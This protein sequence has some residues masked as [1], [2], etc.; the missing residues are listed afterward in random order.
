M[1]IM[2]INRPL[3]QAVLTVLRVLVTGGSGYLGTHVR[4]FFNAEDLSRRSHLDVLSPLDATRVGVYEVVIHLA[5]YS[6]KNPS[7]ADNCFRTNVEG[8]VNLLREMQPNS[9]FIFA[10]SKDVYGAHA[11]EYT[12]VPESC[13][14]EFC[15]QSPLEWSKLIAERYV[16]YYA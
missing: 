8:T 3:P 16:E 2:K 12:D 9:V 10:S 13:S 4:R 15:G 1:R 6:S 11:D 5:A 14:P 7:D